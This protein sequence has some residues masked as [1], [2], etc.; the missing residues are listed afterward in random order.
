VINRERKIDDIL[1][2]AESH[3]FGFK[4]G[5]AASSGRHLSSS[6]TK[7]LSDEKV[8]NIAKATKAQ[9]ENPKVVNKK[10]M[11]AVLDISSLVQPLSR[12]SL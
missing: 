5:T 1:R 10:T 12:F 6:W 11:L 9:E 3:I 2:A 7:T 8:T 4:L